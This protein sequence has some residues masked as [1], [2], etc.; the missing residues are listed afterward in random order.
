MDLF[1]YY[2]IETAL[3]LRNKSWKITEEQ[4][5]SIGD[6]FNPYLNNDKLVL[7]PRFNGSYISFRYCGLEMLRLTKKGQYKIKIRVQ[8]NK[9]RGCPKEIDVDSLQEIKPIIGIA[10]NFLEACI[11]NFKAVA[12]QTKQEKIIPGFSLEHWLESIILAD[13]DVGRDARRCLG[14]SDNLKKVV[15]QAPVIMNPKKKGGRNRHHHIDILGFNENGKTIIIELKKDNDLNKAM[16]ELYEYTNWFMGEGREFHAKRGNPIA[17]M[18]EYYIPRNIVNANPNNINAIA[19]VVD[20]KQPYP[21]LQ[22]GVKL[23]VVGLP[24]DWLQKKGPS[25][26]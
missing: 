7:V 24:S 26:F 10:K 18:N 23:R 8:N 22:N 14:L 21:S 12:K 25:I 1:K 19:V 17:M 11:R 5:K 20:P 16:K 2:A 9:L 15:S 4:I 3:K 6:F 13:N